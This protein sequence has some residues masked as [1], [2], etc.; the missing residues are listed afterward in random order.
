MRDAY[1]NHF[2][3]GSSVMAYYTTCAD[4]N[5]KVSYQYVR[6]QLDASGNVA[7]LFNRYMKSDQY[8]SK[9]IWGTPYSQY[10]R[11]EVSYGKTVVLGKNNNRAIALRV[12][13]GV[14][15]RSRRAAN[16][17]ARRRNS[18]PCDA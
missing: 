5:P 4:L 7:S 17:R 14:G 12:L 15:R 18:R 1:Q 2:D 6:F 10:L 3:L 16:G 13:A 11:S 9:L 8:G